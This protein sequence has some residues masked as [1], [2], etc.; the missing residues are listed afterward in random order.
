MSLDDTLYWEI[1]LYRSVVCLHILQMRKDSSLFQTIFS[2]MFVEQMT[3]RDRDSVSPWSKGQICLLLIAKG[4][5]F[6][7]LKLCSGFDCTSLN[8]NQCPSGPCSEIQY[9]IYIYILLYCQL[10][11][12]IYLYC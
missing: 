8:V 12:K 11:F 4:S 6:I 5:G 1:I 7:Y 3:L 2:R 9:K 10:L